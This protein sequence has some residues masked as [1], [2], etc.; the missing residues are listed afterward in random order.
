MYTGNI[1]DVHNR[2]IFPGAI[3]V[4]DGKITKIEKVSPPEGK[5]LFDHYISP[6]FVDG[7]VHIESSMLI[8]SEF[9]RLASIQGTVATVSDPHEIA[10]VVGID[11]VR[12]MIENGRKTPLKFYF[13]CPSCVPATE[14]ETSGA[15]LGPKECEELLSMPE[16]K[17]LAE[18]MDFPG[19]LCKK[20][21]V[22]E[23]LAIA[24]RFGKPVDGHAPGITGEKA[25]QYID[26]GIHTDHECYKIEEA[27]EKLNWGMKVIIREGSA[28]KNF[29]V[30]HPLIDNYP[31]Q[32]MF[33][34]DDKHPNELIE[35]HMNTICKRAVAY[36]HDLFNV[37]QIACINPIEHYK[38]EVGQLR[39]GDP[40]DFVI[41]ED[42][43]NFKVKAT[44]VNGEKIAEDGKTFIKSV[45]EVPLNNFKCSPKTPADFKVPAKTTKIHLMEAYDGSLLTGHTTTEVKII[46]GH[47][48]SDP[49]N[50][51]I[52]IACV[53]RYMDAPVTTAFIKGFG[54]K[55]GAI[56]CSIAHDSHNIMVAGVE[57]EVICKA[58]NKIIE[59]KGGVCLIKPD[60]DIITLPLPFGGLMSGE[61]GFSIA[62]KYDVLEKEARLVCT[63]MQAPF[64]TMAFMALL[65]IPQIKISDKGLFDGENFAFLEVS[66]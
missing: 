60:G 13:G 35:G 5:T 39:E 15:R 10:N 51:I 59:M 20:P 33:C 27:E 8:P 19:V 49:T 16:V 36:G 7:H 9:A 34:A 12:F 22:M 32:L 18:M 11:G 58:V 54:L 66:A 41:L 64:M 45:T 48:E 14:F 40:A 50:D 38:L 4:K 28:A 47:H 30:L 23:K 26:A 61:D 44:F 63:T 1:V 17:Y 43:K 52:K 31:K 65:V 53:N 6:G 57:D 62:A 42:L 21:E 37:L 24:K 25:K 56:A 3:H 2:T 46:D 55:A 29:E